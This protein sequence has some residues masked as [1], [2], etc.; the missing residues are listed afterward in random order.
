MADAVATFRCLVRR[1]GGGVDELPAGRS[2]EISEIRADPR[3]TVWLALRDPGDAE[4][5]LLA[6][7]FDLHPL[8]IEDVRKRGQRP[9]LDTYADQQM[10]VLYEAL[11]PG[12]APAEDAPTYALAELH[13][14]GG[15]GWL[16][17]VQWG[18]S[19]AVEAGLAQFRRAAGTNHDAGRVVY[20]VFDASADSYFPILDGMAERMDALEDLVLAGGGGADGDGLREMLAIKR[21]LLELRRVLGP[22]RDVANSLLR[23]TNELV[24]DAAEPYFQDLYDHL[25]RL[26]DQLDLYRDLLA[27]VLDARL[28][29][30]SNAL[31]VIMKRL[32]AITL[33]LMVPTLIAGI[34]GMNFVYMPEL[35]WPL[36][37]P[38]ALGLMLVAV[39]AAFAYFR[40]H[41][42]L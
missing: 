30:T 41:D 7:E 15:P 35:D 32:T 11:T 34:Y 20:A 16:V 13:L 29:V 26:L 8:A 40:S 42:W 19:P 3:S 10:L 17:S 27:S 23:R 9:K 28:T 25:V 38:M 4:L 6:D 18:D 12:P 5:R 24:D 22:M 39:V 14:F 2:D 33:I 31:N 21:E 1:H 37:Y 36:G